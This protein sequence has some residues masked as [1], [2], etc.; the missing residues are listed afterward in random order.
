[1]TTSKAARCPLYMR[2]ERFPGPCGAAAAVV[3]AEHDD[4]IARAQQAG[5]RAADEP[6]GVRHD[7]SHA[8]TAG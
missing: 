3:A 5:N 7:N 2:P 1:M 6:C 4:F 8:L